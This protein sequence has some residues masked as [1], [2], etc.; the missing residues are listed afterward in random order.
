M[1]NK[2]ARPCTLFALACLVL[3]CTLGLQP[4]CAHGQSLAELVKER[5][6]LRFA[7]CAGQ[8]GG[9]VGS[10]PRRMPERRAGGE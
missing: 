7:L 9:K 3:L 5:G 6:E 10:W 4:S 8:A 2:A 1:S